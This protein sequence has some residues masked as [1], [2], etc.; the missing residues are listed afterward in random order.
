MAYWGN[1]VG[2]ASRISKIQQM[3]KVKTPVSFIPPDRISLQFDNF[4]MIS[5]FFCAFLAELHQK[6]LVLLSLFLVFCEVLRSRDCLEA[7]TSK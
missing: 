2:I 5:P 6:W 7:K 3:K 4:G 1:F